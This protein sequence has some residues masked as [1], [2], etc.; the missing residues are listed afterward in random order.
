MMREVLLPQA[1]RI[2]VPPF[3]LQSI[4]VFK[5]TSIASVI[6]LIDVTNNAMVIRGNTGSNW[7]VF[8]VLA[9]LYFVVCASVGA[10]G[11]VVEKRLDRGYFMLDRQTTGLESLAPAAT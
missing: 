5:D 3:T 6:G 8:A 1:L 9:L 11:R 2:I 7:D 10:I 4:G